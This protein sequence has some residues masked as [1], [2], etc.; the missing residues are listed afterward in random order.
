MQNWLGENCDGDWEHNENIKIVNID[1]PGW[2]VKINL[3]ETRCENQPYDDLKVEINE[4][5]LYG[6]V[7]LKVQEESIICM[8]FCWNLKHGLKNRIRENVKPLW[9]YISLVDFIFARFW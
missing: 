2:G 5:N 9:K 1:N 6:I 4:D 3:N 7:N 8:I